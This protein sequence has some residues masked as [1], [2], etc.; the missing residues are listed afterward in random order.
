MRSEMCA[1]MLFYCSTYELDFQGFPSSLF[2]KK[3]KQK[4]TSETN[5]K[6]FKK[7]MK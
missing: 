3:G 4:K 7:I 6:I 2:Y 1:A 5:S